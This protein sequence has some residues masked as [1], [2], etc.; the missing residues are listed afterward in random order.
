MRYSCQHCCMDIISLCHLGV[1]CLQ[2]L[3]NC[4][5]VNCIAHW[6]SLRI[7][8]IYQEEGNLATYI[9]SGA[10]LPSLM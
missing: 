4:N 1:C 8:P 7:S 6:K 3:Q 2:V 10:E 5:M 9:I